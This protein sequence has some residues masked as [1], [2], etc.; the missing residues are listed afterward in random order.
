MDPRRPSRSLTGIWVRKRWIICSLLH[1]DHAA[2]GAGH[3]ASRCRRSP[4]GGRARR[5]SGRGCASRS[6]RARGRRGASP[7]PTF[8][9]V[10]LGVEVETISSRP[11]ASACR[12]ARSATWKRRGICG[13]DEHGPAEVDDRP[14]HAVLLQRPRDRARTGLRAGSSPDGRRGPSPVE[15]VVDLAMADTWFPVVIDVGAGARTAS[16]PSAR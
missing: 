5:R 11:C 7:S 9:L 14:A 1:P 8:S 6:P 2:A 12:A 13:V 10:R 3:A 4:S 16:S 15:E